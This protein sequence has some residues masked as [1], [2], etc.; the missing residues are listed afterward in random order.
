MLGKRSALI[1][2]AVALALTPLSAGAQLDPRSKPTTVGPVTFDRDTYPGP[3]CKDG[4]F[5]RNGGTGRVM[6][7]WTFCTFFYRYSAAQ[8]NNSNR[9]FGAMWLATRTNPVNGWCARRV[10]SQLGVQTSGTGK[11]LKR[12]PQGR[13]LGANRSRTVQ[14]RLVVNAGGSGSLKGV[15]KKNWTLHRGD[16]KIRKF[17]RGG[18]TN[19]QLDYE[20]PTEKT[21]SFA[22]AFEMSWPQG[23]RP[24]SI[25]P[26]LRALHVKPCSN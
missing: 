25:F 3:D 8:D 11:V 14:T 16:L 15:L 1:V 21:A 5:R 17:K 13:S 24:P 6:S 18:F 23:G 22:A 9:D 10:V 19:L 4:R 12:A 2:I 26:E 7:K 20:G